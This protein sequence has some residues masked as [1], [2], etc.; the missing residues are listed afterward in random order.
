MQVSRPRKDMM[1]AAS[2]DMIAV[3]PKHIVDATSA[4]N[5]DQFLDEF[6]SKDDPALAVALKRD[7]WNAKKKEN[8]AHKKGSKGEKS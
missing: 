6:V 2:R 7:L 3:N 4:Q 1:D 8:A 5:L